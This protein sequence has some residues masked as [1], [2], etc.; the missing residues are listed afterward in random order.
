LIP[1]AGRFADR[2]NDC[3]NSFLS[4]GWHR[5]W[6]SI[7]PAVTSAGV[8]SEVDVR[9]LSDLAVCVTLPRCSIRGARV[10]DDQDD[11]VRLGDDAANFITGIV[12]K[13]G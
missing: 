1:Q 11:V 13:T 8:A 5:W 6:T 7:A 2:S 9:R 10:C 12:V 3:P 4:Y